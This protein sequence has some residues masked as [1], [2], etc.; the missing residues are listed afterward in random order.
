MRFARRCAAFA[1]CVFGGCG[2]NLDRSGQLNTTH[3]LVVVAHPDDDLLFVQPDLLDAVH[4]GDGVTTMYVTA[5]NGSGGIDKVEPRY[6][7]L[8]QAYGAMAGDFDW[9]CVYIQILGHRLQRC[10]LQQ[11]NL[12]LVFVAYPDG[13]R[14]G[15][16]R[17]SLL[18][19]W[20]GS[21]TSA[22]T[23]DT[24]ETT[25]DREQL[26][27]TLAEVVRQ[28][29]PQV[30]RTLE[31][32]STHGDD[33]PDHMIVGAL[34]VLAMARTDHRAEL[35]S[36]R[37]YNTSAEPA[38][39]IAPLVDPSRAVLARYEACATHCA[40]CGE[41]CTM[42][43]P[44]QEA[45]LARRYAVGFRSAA[46][47]RLQVGKHCLNADDTAP[48]SLGNC[49]VGAVDAAAPGPSTW[50]LQ[51]GQLQTSSG[52]LAVRPN[53]ELQVDACTSQPSQRFF[54]DDE[55]HLWS[56]V[57][58]APE[59]DMYFNHLWCLSPTDAGARAVLCG[60]A[61]APIWSFAP[62]WITTPRSQLQLGATGRAVRLGD[63]TGD[64]HADLCAVQADE[65]YCA[66][67]RGDGEFDAAQRI[68]TGT[69]A[70]DANS[71]ALGDVDGD[72]RA[73]AC[74]RDAA[75]IVC[76]L[77]SHAFT[78]QRFCASFGAGDAVGGTVDS[79]AAVDAD[80]DGI[81]EICGLAAAGVVCAPQ[82]PAKPV[83]RSPWPSRSAIV[84]PADFDGD[85][86]ADWC[87]ATATG[88]ACGVA[89]HH[90][91]SQDG[92]AWGFARDGAVDRV[93]ADPALTAAA[94]IDGDG[95]ADLCTIDG[96]RIECMRS[97]GRGFGPLSTFAVI[98]AG[99]TALWLGDLNGDGAADACVEVGTNVVCVVAK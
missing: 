85:H 9:H 72:Q 11:S 47:G 55:G 68:G 52:C 61:N 26:I 94:D 38:N 34:V 73:D 78:V 96:D 23:V 69:F 36:Y 58:P 93:V 63:L 8:L 5:G 57:P 2:D 24:H 32:A 71:L 50:T 45:W 80:G 49:G 44:D 7:G 99:A 30:V 98:P 62:A 37:G 15:D 12:T 14:L 82:A 41:A 81:A 92:T 33:H 27:D 79:L 16:N 95:D 66:P 48:V 20:Q 3:D 43:D 97:Q 46:R 74:G 4:R 21:I 70:I 25:Y 77:S 86:R 60:K 22:T 91:L 40:A 31:V 39:K 56:G 64:G 76:A 51:A 1:L 59:T 75:G 29:Q 84:W 17:D 54:A 6:A 10:R 42:I 28:T 87:A 65:L 89:A 83:V 53:G 13:G 67:G 19:L 18:H 35:V 88:P 90:D